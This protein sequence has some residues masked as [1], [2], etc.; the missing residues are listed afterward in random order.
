MI[1]K[2]YDF[3]TE[4]GTECFSSY[5]Q[6]ASVHCSSRILPSLPLVHKRFSVVR[7]SLWM[8]ILRWHSWPMPNTRH[9]DEFRC[10]RSTL[11]VPYVNHGY[12]PRCRRG[13]TEN[14]SRSRDSTDGKLTLI[15]MYIYNVDAQATTKAFP[16]RRE[17]YSLTS[18]NRNN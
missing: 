7:L 2:S 9:S 6:K 11:H 15:C 1:D 8:R 12:V 4:F 5:P 10:A 17:L 3:S 16:F 18:L 14:L 13:V